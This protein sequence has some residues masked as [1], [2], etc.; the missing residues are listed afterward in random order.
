MAMDDEVGFSFQQ[1]AF[2]GFAAKTRIE[3]WI[4]PRQS[5]VCGRIMGD[6]NFKIRIHP[7]KLVVGLQKPV[8]ENF[9]NGRNVRP[10]PRCRRVQASGCAE[11]SN[12][13]TSYI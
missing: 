4:F 6:E 13:E 3:S 1:N 8:L 11:D 12:R 2:I 10:L 7:S 5:F 9:F